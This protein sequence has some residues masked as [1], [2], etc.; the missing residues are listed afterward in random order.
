MD[1]DSDPSGHFGRGD[2]GIFSPSPITRLSGL[3]VVS[4]RPSF[5]SRIRL[6]IYS[7][8]EA[9]RPKSP[10]SIRATPVACPPPAASGMLRNSGGA[11][12]TNH[13]GVPREE[14]RG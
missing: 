2:S 8:N 7:R 4:P 13:A 9:S 11:G 12:G 10:Q 3:T 5:D 14:R 1:A 6:V